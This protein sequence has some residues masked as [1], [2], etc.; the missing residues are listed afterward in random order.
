MVLGVPKV[1]LLVRAQL[2]F[3]TSP[4]APVFPVQDPTLYWPVFMPETLGWLNRL[5]ASARN[6]TFHFSR[7][8]NLREVRKSTMSREGERKEFL[9]TLGI[10][11]GLG[12]AQLMP[13]LWEPAQLATV[14]AGVAGFAFV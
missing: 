4:G 8:T 2:K 14:T 12:T 5:N 9:S 13:L 3:P 7:T 10:R 1:A 11:W 6:S